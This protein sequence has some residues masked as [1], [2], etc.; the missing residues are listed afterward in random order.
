MGFKT[1]DKFLDRLCYSGVTACIKK[2]N[3]REAAPKNKEKATTLCDFQ[4]SNSATEFKK[5][6]YTKVAFPKLEMKQ[7][8]VAIPICIGVVLGIYFLYLK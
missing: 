2:N 3:F 6:L 8:I 5:G 4:Q 7:L 1:A